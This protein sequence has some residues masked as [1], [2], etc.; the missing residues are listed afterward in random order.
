[1][2]VAREMRIVVKKRR[3]RNRSLLIGISGNAARMDC[4]GFRGSY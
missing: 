2:D 3:A 1:M 4:E